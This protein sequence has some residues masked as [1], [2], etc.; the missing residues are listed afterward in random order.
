MTGFPQQIT[1]E[2]IPDPEYGGFTAHVPDVPA[3]G[4][5]DTEEEAIASL[6]EALIGYVETFGMADALERMTR[7]SSLRTINW[8]FAQRA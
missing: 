7:P 8:H 4:E 1:V 2:L 5:G 6:Q 3:Y